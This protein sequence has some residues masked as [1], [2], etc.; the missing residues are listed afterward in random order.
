MCGSSSREL[1]PVAIEGSTLRICGRCYAKVKR[2]AK[3]VKE[4]SI[5]SR[6]PPHQEVRPRSVGLKRNEKRSSSGEIELEVTDDYHKVIREARERLGMNT[7]E[8]AER[9]RVQENVIKRFESGKLRPTI[10][11]AKQLERVLKVKL[12]V[13]TEVGEAER[14]EEELTLGDVVNIRGE[15]K[16]D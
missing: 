13:P 2:T 5:Q 16:G 6:K 12:L 11:Q 4:E 8:L 1:I 3:V 14:R 7:K 15:V 9:L 10:Q